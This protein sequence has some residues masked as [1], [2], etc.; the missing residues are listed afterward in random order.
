MTMTDDNVAEASESSIDQVE[1]MLAGRGYEVSRMDNNVVKVRDTES[2]IT[3]RAALEDNVLFLTVPCA[4]VPANAVTP[5][6]MRK[7]L[8]ADNGISTSGFQLYEHGDGRVAVTLN[9]FCK[10]LAMGA[11][12][13]D[14]ILSCLEFLVVDAVDARDLLGDLA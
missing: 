2:G 5:E 4:L 12:D 1:A 14:D 13:E 10:L 8:D 6:M 7:M 9:N 11:D 3:I